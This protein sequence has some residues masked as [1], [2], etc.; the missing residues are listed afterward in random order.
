MHDDI[1]ESI[2]ST[3]LTRGNFDINDYP[4]YKN[5]ATVLK[6]QGY[7]TTPY[8]NTNIF[9]PDEL[10]KIV[11]QSGGWTS[12]KQKENLKKSLADEQAKYNLKISKIQS[13]WIRIP[14]IISSLAFIAS[15]ASI[16]IAYKSY[17]LAESKQS[18]ELKYIKPNDFEK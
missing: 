13:K 16:I 17:K 6:S 9:E 11:L 8:V 3:L 14:Y 12:Y 15:I 5:I 4:N 18:I 2:F 7:L 10:G 1:Y